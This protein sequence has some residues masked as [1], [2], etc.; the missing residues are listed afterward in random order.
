MKVFLLERDVWCCEPC[1][2]QLCDDYGPTDH[3]VTW[4]HLT[5]TSDDPRYIA[6]GKCYKCKGTREEEL[7][8]GIPFS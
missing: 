6:D 3:P 8:E 1:H 2:E 7:N 4:I 5:T